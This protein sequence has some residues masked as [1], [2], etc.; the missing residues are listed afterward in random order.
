MTEPD[1]DVVIVG[2]G[3]AGL[4]AA[5]HLTERGRAVVVCEAGDEVGGRVRTDVVAGFRLDRGFQVLLPAYPEVR[6]VVDVDALALRPFTRGALAV[7]A[8]DRF[9]LAPPWPGR[10]A[11]GGSLAP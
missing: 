3:L 11:A 9:L 1:V 2:A 10:G 6:R 8:S 5:R 7:T 4:A